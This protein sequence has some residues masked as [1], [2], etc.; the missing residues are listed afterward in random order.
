MKDSIRMT[1][2]NIISEYPLVSI[3][4]PV[5]NVS[6]YLAQ[7]LESVIGQTYR[8]IEI[9]VIDD[10]STDNS[11][12]ICDR[13]AESDAR[14][15]VIHT[16][17]R[18]LSAARNTGLDNT[19]GTYTFFIDSDDWIERNAI[20][21]LLKTAIATK[22]DAVKTEISIEYAGKTVH[23]KGVVDHVSTYH[24][25]DIMTAFADGIFGNVVWNK[26]YSSEC[27]TSVR[28][29]VGKNFE[30]VGF[31]CEIMRKLAMNDGTVTAVPEEL[32]H[33]RKRKSSIS[34]NWTWPNLSDSWEAHYSKYRALPE[35]QEKLLGE[36]YIS[37]GHMWMSYYTFS[38]KEKA[39]AAKTIREMK[40]FSK[41]HFHTVIRGKYNNLAKVAC[42]F[43]QSSSKPVFWIS[44]YCGRI[45]QGVL[46]RKQQMYS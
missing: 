9:I 43:S 37:I 1:S 12:S 29:P 44:Y 46:D 30:D 2:E 19:N 4:I 38:D 34:N 24:G 11:G 27:L 20:E 35:I 36:C 32:C 21:Y 33:F 13:Y 7:C 42:V 18:G 14:I 16:S 5:Y 6:C 26:L 17:N 45:R 25:Q 23:P 39:E 8:N 15:H 3:V 40:A 28:F 22:A 10:G 31:T 41:R